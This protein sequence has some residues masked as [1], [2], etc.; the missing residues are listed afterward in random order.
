MKKTY[1]LI[2]ILAFAANAVFAQKYGATPQDS[3]DCII[4]YSVYNELYK[5]N[6][7]KECYEP[8]KKMMKV[9]PARHVNDYIK[10]RTIIKTMIDASTNTTERSKY[11]DELLE[12]SN[13]RTEYFGDE[14]NNIAQKARD[15]S[16]Y[17]PEKVTE[18]YEL[19]K[20]AAEK[21][22]ENLA[23]LYAPLYLEATLLYIKSTGDVENLGLLFD[24]YD[25]TSELCDNALIN[26]EQEIEKTEAAKKSIKTLNKEKADIQSYATTCET[27]IEPYASCDRII[28]IYQTKFDVNP[29]DIN[30]LKKIT[31]TLERKGCTNSPLFFSATEKLHQVE[32]SAKT[33]YMMGVMLMS[34]GQYTESAKYLEEAMNTYK[35]NISKARA[36]KALANAYK[37]ADRYSDA[38]TAANKWGELDKTATG[39]AALFVAELY[40][41]SSASC[42][43]HEGKIRGAAWVA[44][45]EANK[46]QNNYPEIAE[47]AK[48]LMNRAYA[49]FPQKKDIFFVG[50]TEGHSYSVGCWIGKST[51]IRGK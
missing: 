12:L 29:Q 37:G 7:F 21:G 41:A 8:W 42:A 45:D 13:Q 22:K 17:Y 46:I 11:I 4:N 1:L 43:T 2:A 14:A 25:Y 19:Y 50:L 49:Q 20:L 44:W 47:K 51:I 27:Y 31:T 40:Y 35:D 39:E 24:V 36:A 3:V 16:S 28:P 48:S 5:Q 6:S 34:K 15:I 9:C 23:P 38:R 10:G 18:I 32:P 26:I 30:L 33:A